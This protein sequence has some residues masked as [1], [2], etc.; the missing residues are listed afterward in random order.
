MGMFQA[1]VD[2]G[3]ALG[4]LA[5]DISSWSQAT[6]GTDQERG[7]IGPLRH[8]EKEAKEAQQNPGDIT[9]YADCLILILDAARR[10]GF[11]PLPLL[12]AAMQKMEV[13]K[14]RKW[15]KP[16][17]DEPVEHIPGT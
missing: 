1:M 13:N 5:S 7:P 14:A 4:D 17:S 8:L 11:K 15:P 12:R 16:T 6:F 2:A 3:D 10:A 9:E